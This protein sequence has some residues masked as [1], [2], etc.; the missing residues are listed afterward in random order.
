MRV[1][2]SLFLTIFLAIILAKMV[3]Q[4]LL[5]GGSSSNSSSTQVG[6][7]INSPAV[8]VVIYENPI[9]KFVAENYPDAK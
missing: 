2:W 7:K 3:S 6:A 9:Q 5:S 8:P 4:S 1:D